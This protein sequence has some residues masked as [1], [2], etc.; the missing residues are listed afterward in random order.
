M[1][2][3]VAPQLEVVEVMVEAGFAGSVWVED[4]T[5][6]GTGDVITPPMG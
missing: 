3:Y 5:G 4:G 1:G 6:G 2:A